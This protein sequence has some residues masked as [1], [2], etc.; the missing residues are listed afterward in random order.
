MH[1]NA[2]RARVPGATSAATSMCWVTARRG[3]LSVWFFWWHWSL[4]DASRRFGT[5]ENS[6][7][8]ANWLISPWVKAHCSP[9]N[10]PLLL[11]V[12]QQHRRKGYS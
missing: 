10:R 6:K 2:T 12:H 7:A 4:A 3:A 1:S 9:A 5:F 8:V 11:T